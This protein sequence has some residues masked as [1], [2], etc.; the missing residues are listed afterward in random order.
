MG[1]LLLARTGVVGILSVEEVGV[2]DEVVSDVGVSE[3]VLL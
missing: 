3:V 2:L 1:N